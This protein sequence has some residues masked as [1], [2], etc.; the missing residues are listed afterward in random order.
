VANTFVIHTVGPDG[1]KTEHYR[2]TVTTISR[3]AFVSERDAGDPEL[4]TQ[5]PDGTGAKRLTTSPGIDTDPAWSPDGTKLAFTSYRTGNP[6]IYIVNADGTGLR[7]LSND[8]DQ[9]RHPSWS[10]DGTRVVYAGARSLGSIMTV[11][12]ASDGHV[13]A[14]LLFGSGLADLAW[15]PDGRRIAY[16]LPFSSTSTTDTHYHVWVLPADLLAGGGMARQVT[17]SAGDDRYPAW[18]PDGSKLAF[19]ENR[20]GQ[21]DIYV[22]DPLDG[23]VVSR[24]T[25]FAGEDLEPSWS[26]DG[27][28][29]VFASLRATKYDLY[30]V[31]A[32]DGSG[33]VQRTT[34]AAN[35]YMPSWSRCTQ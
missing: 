6:Q 9:D 34:N 21:D 28:Q 33:L 5:L 27:Q 12:A 15:S 3:L 14:S 8:T 1:T 4:Y 32:A 31:N 18:S 22:V 35:D 2:K 16:A 13:I 19:T 30:S 17:N 25:T 10:P 29:I 23:T 20:V 24:L 11:A 7:R 26:P